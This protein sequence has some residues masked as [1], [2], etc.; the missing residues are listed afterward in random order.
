MVPQQ[1]AL[2]S[3]L[4]LDYLRGD[5]SRELR[6]PGGAVP[7]PAEHDLGRH[8]QFDAAL[9]ERRPIKGTRANRQRRSCCR[10]ATATQ[11]S[12]LYGAYVTA[13]GTTRP[14]IAIF[15]ANDGMLHVLERSG[16]AGGRRWPRDFRLCAALA[17]LQPEPS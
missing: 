15:G 8:R 10:L 14:P 3:S 1:A 11:G 16:S 12:S 13:K 9:F 4:V 5:Q 2:G 7:Q 17:V 6:F